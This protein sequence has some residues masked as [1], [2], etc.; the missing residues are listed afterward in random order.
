[1]KAAE[2]PVAELT[3]DQARRELER[4]AKEIAHHDM[5]YHQQDAPEISDAD[6]DALRLRNEAIEARFPKLVRT[7]S[8]SRR[9]GA[10]VAGGFAKV[11]HSR[12]MLSLSNIFE[13]EEVLEFIARVR[14][15]LGLDE[16]DPIEIVAEPKIDG[17]SSS[18]RYEKRAFLRGATRGDGAVGEDITANL[19]TMRDIPETLPKGAP[20]VLEVRG[21]VFMTPRRFLHAQQAPGIGRREDLRQPAKRRSGQPAAA[22]PFDHGAASTALLW[23]RLWRCQRAQG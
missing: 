20:D 12:P 2:I 13:D 1:M 18:L 15:F 17:L 5:L 21:E 8:P 16:G 14:R 6:Y 11:K 3:D 23:V 22:R 10:P 4:L 19:R 7:D 9:I